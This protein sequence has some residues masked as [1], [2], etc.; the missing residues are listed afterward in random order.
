MLGVEAE[1]N[2]GISPTY[3]KGHLARCT[4]CCCSTGCSCSIS[5]SSIPRASFQ[6]AL[7]RNGRKAIA[8]EDSVGKPA[9][10]DVLF[11]RDPIAEADHPEN[12]QMPCRALSLEQLIKLIIVYEL[13]GLNDIAVDTVERFANRLKARLDTEHAMRLLADPPLPAGSAAAVHAECTA[14][15]EAAGASSARNGGIG[16]RIFNGALGAVAWYQGKIEGKQRWYYNTLHL[17]A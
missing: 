3:P 13:H 7:V 12:Y 6:R 9:K 16:L 14:L 15:G 11:C 17:S 4:R 2:F 10:L 1:S 5:G 8:G